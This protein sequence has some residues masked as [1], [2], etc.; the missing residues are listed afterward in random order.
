MHVHIRSDDAINEE[1]SVE[2][3]TFDVVRSIRARRLKWVGHIL[4]MH[5][6]TL[7]LKTL[8]HIQKKITKKVTC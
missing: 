5:T 4:H 2:T 3:R 8:S 7:I 6:K 1:V